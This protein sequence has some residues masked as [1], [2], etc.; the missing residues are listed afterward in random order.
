MTPRERSLVRTAVAAALLGGVMWGYVRL[1]AARDA[2]AGAAASL[3]ECRRLAA[4]V[5]SRRGPGAVVVAGAEEPRATELIKRIESAAKAAGFPQ[6]GIER[7]QPGSPR[8]LS[9]DDTLFEKPT[10]I[11]LRDVTLRQVFTF[12]HA[13]GGGGGAGKPGLQLKDVRLTAPSPG[14]TGDRWSVEG[15]L[16]YLVRAPEDGPRR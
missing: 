13:V 4:A 6:D 11:Q 1:T 5:E 7:I 16:T 9:G 8:R 3:A 2:A 15:T 12:L 10:D 14:D